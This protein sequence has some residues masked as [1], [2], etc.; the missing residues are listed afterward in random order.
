M[1]IRQI[2]QPVFAVIERLLDRV[3][4]LVGRSTADAPLI[5]PYIGYVTPER[6]RMRGRVLEDEGIQPANRDDSRWRN[7]LAMIR[8]FESDELPNAPLDVVFNA[9]HNWIS[10]DDEGYFDLDLALYSHLPAT[11]R[12]WP[13]KVR[14]L[15]DPRKPGTGPGISAMG[16][17]IAPAATAQFGVISDLDDTVLR[18]DAFNAVRVL[19]NTFFQNAQT[20]L[21]FEGVADFYQALQTGTQGTF[22]PIFYVSSSPWN[23]YDFIIEFFEVHNIP[24][25]PIFLQDIGIGPSKLITQPHSDHKRRYIDQVLTDFPDLPF[26]L[27]GDSGQHDPEIYAKVIADYPGRIAAVYI[28][29]VREGGRADEI[30]RL[31]EEASRHEVDMLLVKDTY[32]AA[33]HALANGYIADDALLMVQNT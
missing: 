11:Q 22:N 28:R 17:V 15:E 18:S 30:Q 12:H 33:Q 16:T 3:A 32:A 2:L 13:V 8:R 1:G 20:R 19:M 26:I 24:T 25:G 29:D 4:R 27:I 21:P 14:L 6:V 5:Q 10:T 7:L 31:I 9:H 23:L